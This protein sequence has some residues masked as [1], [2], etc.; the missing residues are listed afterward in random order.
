MAR[1]DAAALVAAALGPI[2]PPAALSGAALQFTLFDP[3]RPPTAA[4][5][6]PRYAAAH[7]SIEVVVSGSNLAPTGGSLLCRFDGD[8]RTTVG[9]WPKP[10][11]PKPE[12]E[13][14]P[15][16]P[17]ASDSASA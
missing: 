14:K 13:P 6:V 8:A 1:H 9:R 10:P 4:A 3:S 5:A 16:T 11:E 12:P 15:Y 2:R 7:A 17:P